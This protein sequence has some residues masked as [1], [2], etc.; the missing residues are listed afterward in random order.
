MS[1]RG[2]F[3]RP[4][5]TAGPAQIDAFALSVRQHVE[6]VEALPALRGTKSSPHP[7]FGAFDAHQ[8]NCM[9]AFHLRLHLRQARFVVEN[10]RRR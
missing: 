3:A 5:D 6:A 8:W 7:V 2:R 1:R 9:F 4:R 10:A